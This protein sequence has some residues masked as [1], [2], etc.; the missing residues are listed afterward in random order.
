MMDHRDGWRDESVREICAGQNDLMI[1]MIE[2]IFKS[3]VQSVDA[4]VVLPT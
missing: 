1:M 3:L 2:R 4:T